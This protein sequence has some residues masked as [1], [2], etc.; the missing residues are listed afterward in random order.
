[1]SK[2]GYIL[3]EDFVA[4]VCGN[5]LHQIQKQDNEDL[6]K[7]VIELLTKED[8]NSLDLL[9]NID[10]SI[11]V[12]SHGNIEVK[13][14][15]VL[16]KG[17]VLHDVIVDQILAFVHKG[18]PYKPLVKFLN[19]LMENLNPVARKSLY[20]FMVANGL[21][22]CDDGDFLAYKYITKDWKDNYTRKVDNRIGCKPRMERT[23]VDNNGDLCS[24]KGYHV[25]NID[26]AL[27]RVNSPDYRAVICKVN[28]ADVVIVPTR[29]NSKIRVCA[30]EVVAE[31]QRPMEKYEKVSKL[32]EESGIS[33]LPSFETAKA[34]LEKI[35]SEAKSDR[36]VGL[37]RIAKRFKISLDEVVNLIEKTE[38]KKHFSIVSLDREVKGHWIVEEKKKF[39]SNT[40]VVEPNNIKNAKEFG[41][42]KELDEVLTS[43][44][45]ST[46]AKFNKYLEEKAAQGVVY[47]T[48][49]QLRKRFNYKVSK[50]FALIEYYDYKY[51][52]DPIAPNNVG[53]IR[54]STANEPQKINV[55]DETLEILANKYPKSTIDEYFAEKAR[56]LYKHVTVDQL[57]KRFGLKVWQAFALVEYYG[58]IFHQNPKY[59]NNLSK[60]KVETE[61]E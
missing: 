41:N 25:G 8:W 48:I 14:E 13:E 29:D 6:Y 23:E 33:R 58:Y 17:Q 50:A 31:Y 36:D 32:K 37:R 34:Y 2:N 60:I 1:M 57:R 39:T 53:K 15:V 42:A 30:Y 59:P 27:N 43:T 45:N 54:V 11:S 22:I 26:Y 20:E 61:N 55:S 51:E 52:R 44:R 18:F 10:K 3:N 49:D 46:K 24:A 7:Q 12:F 4:V 56:K 47:V 9:L 38:L 5:K 16:Y 35:I 19:K 40:E 21:T 28:P